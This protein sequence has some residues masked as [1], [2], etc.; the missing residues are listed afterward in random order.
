MPD[1]DQKKVKTE[2]AKDVNKRLDQVIRKSNAQKKILRKI[3]DQ[4]NR[5]SKEADHSGLHSADK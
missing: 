3:L 4:L 1:K 2:E 5:Q